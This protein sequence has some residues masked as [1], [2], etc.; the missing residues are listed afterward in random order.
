M[1]VHRKLGYVP[2]DGGPNQIGNVED[3]LVRPDNTHMNAQEQSAF[4]EGQLSRGGVQQD[5][6]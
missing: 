1:P 3:G 5:G 4:D 6:C 2:S